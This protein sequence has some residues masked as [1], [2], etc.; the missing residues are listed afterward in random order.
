M[1]NGTSDNN[2]DC[3]HNQKDLKNE[4]NGFSVRPLFMKITKYTRRLFFSSHIQ[5]F[6]YLFLFFGEKYRERVSF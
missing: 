1:N 5:I 2:N 6:F 4:K 3:E